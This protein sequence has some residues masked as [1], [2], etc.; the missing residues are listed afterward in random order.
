MADFVV[1]KRISEVAYLWGF[2]RTGR[3]SEVQHCKSKM[4][5]SWEEEVRYFDIDVFIYSLHDRETQDEELV[6]FCLHQGIPRAAPLRSCS[7]SCSNWIQFRPTIL[8]NK[9][10]IVVEPS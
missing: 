6:A 10:Y 7:S 1:Q 4:I 5:A 8:S 3:G 9:M 2:V